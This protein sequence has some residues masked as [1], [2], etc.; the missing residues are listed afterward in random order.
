MNMNNV[1]RK[2]S[3]YNYYAEQVTQFMAQ[4]DLIFDEEVPLMEE[5]IR[6]CA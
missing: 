5:F 1:V 6:G 2:M 3:H 4:H